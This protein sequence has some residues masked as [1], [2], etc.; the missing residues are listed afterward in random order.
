MTYQSSAQNTFND[1][2]DH[3]LDGYNTNDLTEMK[4]GSEDL[5]ADFSDEF[6][7]FYLNAYYQILK[8]DLATAQSANKQAMNIHPLMEYPYYTQAYIDF[9]NGNTNAAL[10]NLEWASQLCTFNTADDILKDMGIIERFTKKDLSILKT[11]WQSFFQDNKINTQ[12]ALQLS[13]CI[14][15]LFVQGQKCTDLDPLFAHFSSLPETNPIFQKLLPVLKALSLYY[16]G[17]TK[18]SKQQLENFIKLSNNDPKLHWRRS[19]ALHFLSVIKDNSFDTRGALL[20]INTALTDYNHLSYPSV[21]QAYMT[22]HKM[23]VLSRLDAQKQD[24]V[25]TAYQLEQIADKINNDYYRAK[26]YG[27]LGTQNFFSLDPTEKTKAHSYVMKA[28]TSA[29]KI[30]DEK[31]LASIKNNYALVKAD[32]G[33]YTEASKIIQEVAQTHIANKKYQDAQNA[34]NNLGAIYYK[35]KDYINANEQFEK[36]VALIGK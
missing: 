21:H 14:S 28:Y 17:D 36:S 9:L 27:T 7:G 19:H 34:Y 6:A 23:N 12:K 11:K 32:Q 2:Y 24:I 15:G 35:Q 3:Y 33:L 29:E 4:K 13:Q 22:N 16:G 18:G 26:A 25:H 30:N 8:G 20:D 31:L 5:M 1:Y 10:Q